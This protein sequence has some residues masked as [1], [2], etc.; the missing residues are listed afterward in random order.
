MQV[1][2]TALAP[3]LKRLAERAATCFLHLTPTSA[4]APEPEVLILIGAGFN[5]ASTLIPAWFIWSTSNIVIT[6]VIGS[7]LLNT[8]GPVVE[9]FGLTVR[10]AFS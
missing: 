10:N 7:I 5:P 8:L 4:R 1:L 3:G 9:R 2:V 6:L